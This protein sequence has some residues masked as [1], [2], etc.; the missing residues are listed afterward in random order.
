MN[1]LANQTISLEEDEANK[2]DRPIPSKRISLHTAIVLR[3][4]VPFLDLAWSAMY[5]K[6]VFFA[7]LACCVV[8]WAY[9]DLRLASG[10]W[11]GRNLFI[12]L[13]MAVMEVGACLLAGMFHCFFTSLTLGC[14]IYCGSGQVYHTL[15]MTCITAI[16]CSCL[17]CV[18]TFQAGDFKDIEGKLFNLITFPEY[19]TLTVIQ[20]IFSLAAKPY[21]LFILNS[22]APP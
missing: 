6:E 19:A 10:H 22:P 20:E 5:S 12:G 11:A 2:K 3:W 13:G 15:D 14:S 16:V 4:I 9:N 17:I 21:R 7:S 18:T 8:V 1:S